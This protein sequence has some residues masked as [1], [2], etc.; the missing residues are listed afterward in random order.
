VTSRLGE[1]VV[2]HVAVEDRG[3]NGRCLCCTFSVC[4]KETLISK[5]IAQRALRADVE[6]TKTYRCRNC[7]FAFHGRGL[8]SE[9]AKNYYTNYRD[10]EYF[11]HRNHCEPLYTLGHHNRLEAHVRSAER[12][13]K[14]QQYL[15][16]NVFPAFDEL[17]EVKILDY[18]GGDG[19]LVA[20]LPYEKYVF[21]LSGEDPIADVIK[22][23]RGEIARQKFDLVICAQMLEHT[24]DPAQVIEELLGHVN[25]G[26][27]LYVE[28]PYRETWLDLSGSSSVR[29][30]VLR[31]VEMNPKLELILDTYGTLIRRATGILPPLAYVSVREHLNFFTPK[32]LSELT[33]SIQALEIDCSRQKT[34]GTVLLL[35]KI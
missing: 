35:R 25:Q 24:T 5:F 33:R 4:G 16:Q 12:R 3:A 27:Y 7:G 21:D 19:H 1:S 9:E 2:S 28:V 29:R 18:A 26:G 30:R 13:A 15:N 34:L 8:T 22:L 20:D 31:V 10:A 6:R 17:E 23:D 14:L 11:R 32:S